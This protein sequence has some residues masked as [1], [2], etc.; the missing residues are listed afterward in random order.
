MYQYW[1]NK[2]NESTTLIQNVNNMGN[3]SCVGV[4]AYMGTLYFLLN[5][6]VN[7]K[8]TIKNKVY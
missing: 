8:T 6:S 4:K 2:Y 5:I 1:L 3:Y 7:M